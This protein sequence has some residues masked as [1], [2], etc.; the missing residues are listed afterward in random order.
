VVTQDVTEEVTRVI[1][2][3]VTVTPSATPAFTATPV[4]GAT[5]NGTPTITPT[6]GPA[7]TPEPPVVSV[8]EYSDCLYGPASFYLYK[9]SLLAGSVMEAVGR[10]PEGTWL[11]VQEVHGWNP[12]WIEAARVKF[13]SGDVTVV[14][15]V[16]SVLPYSNQYAPPDASARRNGNEV[17]VSWKA[18]WM[19]FDDYR[20][21]LI[22]AWVCQGGKQ[23]F[24]PVSYV[25]ALDANTGS[26]SVKIIDEPGCDQPS[27]ARI[28]S[29]DKY[30]YSAWQI[31]FW[32]QP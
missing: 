25:P 19:S 8:P 4:P 32:P 26:L 30:G 9:T 28:Y 13:N 21:Y 18:V 3:P 27:H 20:G 23:V 7:P 6:L 24:L 22:E 10:N 14:P 2:V 16:Y 15:V 31:I 29:A 11:D 12:C 5:L 17:T 1:E